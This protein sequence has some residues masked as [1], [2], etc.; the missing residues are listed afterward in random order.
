[1]YRRQ[2]QAQPTMVLT[3]CDLLHFVAH[4]DPQTRRYFFAE[5]ELC[6]LEDVLGQLVGYLCAALFPRQE[7]STGPLER[8]A[9][10]QEA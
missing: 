2:Q 4:Y 3:A 7:K 8:S 1:S 6:T 10:L 5:E 9:I